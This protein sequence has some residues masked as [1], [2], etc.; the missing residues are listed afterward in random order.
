[1][2]NIIRK[3][4]NW[5]TQYSRPEQDELVLALVLNTASLGLKRDDFVEFA[6]VKSV[7]G[8]FKL[9]GNSLPCFTYTVFEKKI[10]EFIEVRVEVARPSVIRFISKI[11]STDKEQDG[12]EIET[13]EK[14]KEP[15]LK[16]AG[17]LFNYFPFPMEGGRI[18]NEKST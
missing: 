15:F 17:Y 8:P 3:L 2:K 11:K 13:T 5:L 1:M 18:K 4:N 10:M 6:P 9:T 7:C 14:Y 16:L 12:K